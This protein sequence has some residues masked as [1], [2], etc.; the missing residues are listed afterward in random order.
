M[1]SSGLPRVLRGILIDT[2]GAC[3]KESNPEGVRSEEAK[4]HEEQLKELMILGLKKK[5]N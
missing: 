4:S 3:P 1:F 5:L 2:T